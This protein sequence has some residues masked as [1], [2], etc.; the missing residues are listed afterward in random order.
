M[1]ARSVGRLYDE[2]LAPAELN[3]TQYAILA[4]IHRSGKLPTVALANL[5]NL[6]RTTL[7]RAL[8]ILERRGFVR[9]K[10]GKGR[11]Q[12]VSL[13]RAGEA[14]RAEAEPLW[15]KAQHGFMRSFGSDWPELLDLLRKAQSLSP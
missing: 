5:L 13:T 12:I 1:A 4:N 6:E 14:K 15:K 11:E 9:S 2:A 7:Y 3:S 8:A 10:P